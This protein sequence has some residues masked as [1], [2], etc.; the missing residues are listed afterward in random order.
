MSQEVNK[1]AQVQ[2][3]CYARSKSQ[4]VSKQERKR[5]TSQVRNAWDEKV[6]IQAL[7]FARLPSLRDRGEV[8]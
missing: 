3:P 1:V 5:T 8:M 6:L 7:C 2:P 4:E